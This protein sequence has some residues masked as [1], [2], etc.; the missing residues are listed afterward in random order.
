MAA[1]PINRAF[2]NREAIKYS[3]SN[4]VFHLS[5]SLLFQ[6]FCSNVPMMMVLL[7]T[8]KQ[9]FEGK[10]RNVSRISINPYWVELDVIFQGG[11]S[12]KV[13]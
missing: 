5:R 9:L 2:S 11:C 8:T 3:S 1:P 6:I 4:Y 10:V 7:T 13:F 12:S